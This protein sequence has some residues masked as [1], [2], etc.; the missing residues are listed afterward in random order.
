M[1]NS[2]FLKEVKLYSLAKKQFCFNEAV[3][4][5]QFE[6]LYK[7]LK[8][9]VL[10]NLNIVFDLKGEKTPII[11]GN[12]NTVVALDCQR[13]LEV[14]NFE[15]ASDINFSFIKEGKDTQEMAVETL[16]YQDKV[17]V[18]EVV[19]E[20]LLLELPMI[21]KHKE[22]TVKYAKNYEEESFKEMKEFEE[23][24]SKINPFAILSK[25]KN[26]KET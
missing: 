4:L 18:F 13:C 23:L 20:A 5:K 14:M 12:I 3:S 7:V 15:L 26:L 24:E 2:D 9:D 25:L 16:T 6:R 21:A 17:N 8:Q 1:K 10:V 11:Q 19:E 22:C